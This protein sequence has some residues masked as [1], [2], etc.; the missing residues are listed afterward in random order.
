MGVACV[1][2]VLGGCCSARGA[3]DC[4]FAPGFDGSAFDGSGAPLACSAWICVRGT[5]GGGV[6]FAQGAGVVD[7]MGEG[8]GPEPSADGAD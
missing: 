2:W 4:G 8:G 7:S 3:L 1:C 5:T 6:V